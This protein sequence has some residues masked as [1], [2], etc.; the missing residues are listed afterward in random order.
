MKP[1]DRISE[2]FN[3]KHCPWCRWNTE[4]FPG[5]AVCIHPK[6]YPTR[7]GVADEPCTKEDWENCPYNGGKS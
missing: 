5:K 6:H 7:A 2:K 4:N 3:P 1:I